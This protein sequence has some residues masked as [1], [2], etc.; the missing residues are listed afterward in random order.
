MRLLATMLASFLAM[1][2]VGPGILAHS[3]IPHSQ[4]PGSALTLNSSIQTHQEAIHSVQF[5]KPHK[6]SLAVSGRGNLMPSFVAAVKQRYPGVTVYD[7]N[8]EASR[9]PSN[10]AIPRHP[11]VA[12]IDVVFIEH[13]A[14][15]SATIRSP[16]NHRFFNYDPSQYGNDPTRSSLLMN[17]MLQTVWDLLHEASTPPV[18]DLPEEQE[19]ADDGPE[20]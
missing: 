17:R 9:P 3:E 14:F 2:A 13:D 20:S 16:R 11:E 10:A 18:I 6:F 19:T 7:R 12:D 1:P 4:G 15:E 5:Q 8:E